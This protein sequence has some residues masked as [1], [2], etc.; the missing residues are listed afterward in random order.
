M[1]NDMEFTISARDQAS[2]AVETVKK[3]LQSFGSDVAKL[4]LGFAAPLALAQAAFSAIGDAIEEHK[5]KVQEAIDNTAELS[6]KASDLGVSVE[7][8]QKLSNAADAAGM[9]LDKVAKAY[10]EVQKLLAGAVGGGNDTAKMLEVLGFA[11]DDIAKG[12]VKPM[13]VIEKLGAAMLGAKDDSTA[14]KI[15]T[16]VLGET[17]AKD[18]L[19]QLKAAMDLAAGFSEDSGITQE[20]AELIRQ[21]KIKEKQ[22]KNREEAA[23]AK[24]EVAK[25]FLKTD[26]G[27]GDVAN[28]FGRELT[29]S[30]R[31]LLTRGK[32]NELAGNEEV[33]NEIMRI[34]KERAA[35]EKERLRIANEGKANEIIAAAEAAAAEKE[36]QDAADKAIQESMTQAEKDEKKAREDA[37]KAA[38][39]AKT[40]ADKAKQKAEDDAKK[41]AEDKE[42]KDK[43]DLGKALDAEE[44]A[45]ASEGSKLTLSS[46]REIGGGLAGE[47]LVNAADMD[48]QML[49]INT[50]MLIEL[51]KL[52]VKTL[53]E[54]PTS[55]DFTKLQT[56]A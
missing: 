6:N 38:E 27:A 9:S 39:K 28:K 1:A 31:R 5:K 8:Y 52:N 11:A 20:E 10:T 33:Q 15:A 4:A 25:E 3:K 16:A 29:E 30:G 46:L 56:T 42:K 17:L 51:Q 24:E 12:L 47:A 55:T 13:D 21:K 35:A 2:K 36:A 43:D 48:R 50:K 18:L 37:D 54:V 23:L 7:E 19:P 22:T 44:K 53:P 40:D 49:D 14:F 45:K 32:I 41:A 34:L 26:P